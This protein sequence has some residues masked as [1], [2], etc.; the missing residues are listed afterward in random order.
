MIEK[1]LVWDESTSNGRHSA[2]AVEAA[3]QEAAREHEPTE[4][5]AATWHGRAILGMVTGVLSGLLG[6]RIL[7]D[8]LGEEHSIEAIDMYA[9]VI[10]PVV[11][12]FAGL[13]PPLDVL[14]LALP[15]GPLLA[16]GVLWTLHLL[17]IAFLHAL[18]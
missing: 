3:W 2:R 7:S 9:S 18:D 17:M 6:T 8:I 11:W 12:P 16:L 14:G 5:I 10:A 15:S 1:E 13:L 4:A